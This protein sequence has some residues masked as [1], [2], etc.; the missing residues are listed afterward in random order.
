M[1]YFN[2]CPRCKTGTVK[3]DSD[4]YGS[5]LSCLNCGFEKSA[6]SVRKMTFEESELE[7]VTAQPVLA[8]VGD[9]YSEDDDDDYED[10]FDD[11]DVEELERAV[12]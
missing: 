7:P 4:F 8:L 12:G 1:L 5:F 11:E 9:A 10:D 6:A 2:A 3:L